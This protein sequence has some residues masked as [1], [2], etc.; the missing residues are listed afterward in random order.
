MGRYRGMSAMLKRLR[1]RQVMT[2]EELALKAGT[3]QQ[4]IA[5]LESGSR[6][7]PSLELLHRLAKALKVKVADL[8]E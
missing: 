3:T 6:K 7:N 8:L 1:E 4:Y 5:M 2:Q